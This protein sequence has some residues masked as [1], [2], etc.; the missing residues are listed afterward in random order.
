MV[1]DSPLGMY[2]ISPG[3]AVTVPALV[4]TDSPLEDGR[5]GRLDV[6]R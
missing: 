6:A 5:I 4:E 1:T 3:P 2:T